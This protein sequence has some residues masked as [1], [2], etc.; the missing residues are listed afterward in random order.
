MLARSGGTK[1]TERAV[2]GALIWLARPPNLRR[3]LEPARTTLQRCNDAHLHRAGQRATPTPAP[4]PWACCPSWP[5]ARRTR[6]RARTGQTSPAAST[7]SSS[8]QKPDGDLAN[9]CPQTMYSH[10]LATIALCEAYGLTGD[11]NVGMAA[12]GAV[13]LHHQRPEQGHRRL[14]VHPRRRRRH[15]GGR[16]ADHGPEERQMAGLSGSAAAACRSTAPASGSTPCS[17]GA[18]NSHLLLPARQRPAGHHDRRRP[19]LPA[20]P[21]RQARQPDDDRRREVPDGPT[22][23]TETPPRLNIY[24]WYYATQ[25]MHNMNGYEWD[26]V[27]PEDAE[28]PG[29][30]RSA[31]TAALVPTGVGTRPA[32]SGPAAA[33]G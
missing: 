23:P 3:K 11:K 15:L 8:H 27:E 32:T 1:H 12:Q 31:A 18:N 22:C 10:G 6:P 29:R 17:S 28:D 33:A 14:A 30:V 2:T 20:V 4:P 21:G 19:A 7:G 24:Y 13:N 9:G 25:V 16:L 5:P 26:T